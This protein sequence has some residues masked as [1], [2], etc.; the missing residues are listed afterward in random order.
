MNQNIGILVADDDAKMRDLL[1]WILKGFGYT[2]LFHASNGDRAMRAL[3]KEQ[4]GIAFLDIEM[5]DH[6]GIDVLKQI[7]AKHPAC[8]CVMVTAHSSAANVKEALTAGAKGFIVKPFRA[9]RVEDVLAKFER[10]T[11]AHAPQ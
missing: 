5:P 9:N 1:A 6:S 7:A 2:N 10:T 4:I 3:E 8:F 11:T